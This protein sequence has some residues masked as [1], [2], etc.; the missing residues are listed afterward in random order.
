MEI[1]LTGATGFL[2]KQVLRLLLADGHTVYSLT[3][4]A[5]QLATPN[6]IEVSGDLVSDKWTADVPWGRIDAVVHL[7]ASGVKAS[8][9]NWRE[10]FEVNVGG[11][12]KLLET[13]KAKATKKP[14]LIVTRSFYER[15]M[16]Q[17]SALRENAYISTKSI[18]TEII[19][20]WSK[21]YSGSVCFAT[22][23]QIYGPGDDGGSVLSY[24]AHQFAAKH[25]AK[26]GSGQ[27]NRDWLYLDDA[28]TALVLLMTMQSDGV[29]DWDIGSGKL[30]S[31]RVMVETLARIADTGPEMLD[32][33]ASRDRADT[34]L[35]LIAE[36]LPP[37]WSP[38]ISQEEG[39]RRMW[40][41]TDLK[42]SEQGTKN[43]LS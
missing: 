17:E 4:H 35:H 11:T 23:F 31:L 6:M 8:H 24:A 1:F 36:L 15:V 33:D 13:I 14:R 27:G 7:A 32:F 39:L 42:S 30:N 21:D 20:A 16:H 12:F 3:R 41:A 5:S 34:A 43:S 22:L 26:F 10:A 18:S 38:S 28:A 19:K 25:Q 29:T 9:R 40:I 37:G 2:G